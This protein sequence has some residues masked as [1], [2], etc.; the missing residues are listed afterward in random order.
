MPEQRLTFVKYSKTEIYVRP[1]GHNEGVVYNL[2]KCK[3]ISQSDWV[4][5]VIEFSF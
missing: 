5:N 3:I 1:D 4:V 2:Y